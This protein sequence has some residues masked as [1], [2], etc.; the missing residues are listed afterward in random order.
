MPSDLSQKELALIVGPAAI[1]KSTLMR[2]VVELDDDFGV[3]SGF[4]SR[5]PRLNDEGGRYRY[6]SADDVEA[7]IA[8]PETIQ[9]AVH[10]TTG[11]VYGTQLQ[12]YAAQYNL[13]DTLS[14]VADQLRTLPFRKTTIISLTAP[15]ADWQEW[16]FA[17]YPSASV[18]RRKRLEEA[19]Q[20]IRWSLNQTEH[21]WLVNHQSDVDSV[22]TSLIHLVKN[23]ASTKPVNGRQVAED[24]LATIETLLSYEQKESYGQA[25]PTKL[26][27]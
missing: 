23:G 16:F 5:P 22:A 26:P 6:I 27:E 15:S 12:D 21:Y 25:S 20:S 24:L 18:E 10:P 1:G 19:A 7:V 14:S 8:S 13:L 17:R 2:R 3:V 9:Y 11:F 4:T